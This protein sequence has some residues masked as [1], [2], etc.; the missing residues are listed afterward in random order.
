MSDALLKEISTKLDNIAGLLSKSGSGGAVA[1]KAGAAGGT[2]AGGTDDAKVAAAKAAAAK[3]AAAKKTAEDAAKKK[4]GA[5]TGTKAP[6]GKHTIDQVRTMIREV[7]A[8]VD[9]QSAKDILSDDG[10]GVEKV[11]DLKPEFY[12]KVYEACEVLLK[13]EGGAGAAPPADEE[14]DFA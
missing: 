8:K 9:K 5:T 10:G 6:G 14:D 7:A 11:L 1:P 4:A 2:P 3:A 12:D 13:G